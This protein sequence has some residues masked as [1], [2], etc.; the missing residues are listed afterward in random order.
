M[1]FLKN[2][3][4]AEKFSI[5]ICHQRTDDF[6]WKS[7]L[8]S[9]V[10]SI[11]GKLFFVTSQQFR[12]EPEACSGFNAVVLLNYSKTLLSSTVYCPV[13]LDI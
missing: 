6:S 5:H 9:P 8:F 2:V 7:V 4:M 1:F 13:L 10:S 3:V 11:Q 12:K